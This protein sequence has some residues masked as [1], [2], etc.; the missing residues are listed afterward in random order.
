[1]KKATLTIG[2]FSLLM[3]LTSFTTPETTTG[4]KV[5]QNNMLI[6]PIDGAGGQ[7]T[8]GNRKVDVYIDGAGGQSTGGNRKVDVYIDGAGGQSTGGNRKVD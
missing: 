6:S 2:L 5:T 3:V 1:M 7:S 4:I 8:G